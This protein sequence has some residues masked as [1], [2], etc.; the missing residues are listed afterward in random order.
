MK[1]QLVADE[2][3]LTKVVS[4]VEAIVHAYHNNKTVFAAGNGGSASDSQHFV[5]ELVGRFKFD[6]P[7]LRA[8]SLS[9]NM[10][11]ITC[12]G[13]DYGYEDIFSRQIEGCGVEG[14]VFLA[15]SPIFDLLNDKAFGHR[16]GLRPPD[17]RFRAQREGVGSGS[18][19]HDD[20]LD[21]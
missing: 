19:G 6:R 18:H 9:A 7:P 1:T 11:N 12:I 2:N 4:C 17:G 15:N 5:A 13:N 16:H 3:T 14:D 8:Y 10:S 21:M 20:P